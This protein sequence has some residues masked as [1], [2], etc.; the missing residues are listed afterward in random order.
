MISEKENE[1]AIEDNGKESIADR[2]RTLI[3]NRTVRAAA[4]DWGLSFSTLNNYL[5]RGTIPSLKVAIS[6]ARKENVSIGWIGN[7]VETVVCDEIHSSTSSEKT[8]QSAVDNSIQTAMTATP[9]KDEKFLSLTWAMFFEAL[10][11]QEKNQ[12]IDVFAKIGVKGVLALLSGETSHAEKWLTLSPNEQERLLRLH[13]QLKKGTPEADR[14]VAD[15]D[16]TINDKK[17]G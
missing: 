3:G 13:E 5:T 14:S 11:S 1:L 2:L 15:S 16:L 10:N 8:H 17:A 12:L 6:I 9:I 4:N 7:G